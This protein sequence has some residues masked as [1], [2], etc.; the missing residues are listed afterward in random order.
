[1]IAIWPAGPPKLMKPS[2]NQKRSASRNETSLIARARCGRPT[3]SAS[4][5]S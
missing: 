3:P 1:M 5:R 2:V 4:A